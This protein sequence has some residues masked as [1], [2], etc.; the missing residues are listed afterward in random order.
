MPEFI[1][2][3]PYNPNWPD[4]FETKAKEV[5]EALGTNCIAI[6][7]VGSTSVPG[8]AS[9]PKIDI[10]AVVRN[11]IFPE[12]TLKNLGYIYKGG[13]NIPLRRSFD[14][15]QQPIDINLHIFE[16]N[17]PEIELNLLFR[18]YL[19][20]NPETRQQYQ[21]LKYDLISVASSHKKEGVFYKGYTLGKNDFIQDVL[22]RARFHKPRFVI[23]THHPEFEAA[24]L[25][26]QKYFF[27]KAHIRDPYHW[28]FNHPEHEHLILYLG[29]RIAGYSHIQLWKDLR[30]AT[31]IIVIDEPYRGQG[32]GARL[33]SLIEKYLKMKGIKSLHTESSPAA[34]AFYLKE[35][36]VDM[37][38]DD[39]DEHEGNKMD[40]PVGK[41][42]Q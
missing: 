6:H 35:G 26:R 14:L 42:L 7:H 16:E 40:R 27:D 22:E 37:P 41:K 29:T 20:E 9:K 1:K 31:R 28:T 18:N 11:L 8:L 36:Y 33:L 13:F 24:K 3:A 39:P 21:K 12:N 32:L 17:D 25:F 34:L 4:L 2:I 10:I 23:C 5:K 15:N 38:F 30:A 19:R